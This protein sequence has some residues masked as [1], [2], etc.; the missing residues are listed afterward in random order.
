MN[1]N[2]NNVLILG[3]VLIIFCTSCA[4][5][6]QFLSAYDLDKAPVPLVLNKTKTDS[7]VI[8]FKGDNRQ[9]LLLKN[10]KDT[11]FK[12]YNI[13]SVMFKSATGNQLN[14]WMIKDSVN[15]NNGKT[16]LYFHGAGGC[17]LTQFSFMVPFEKKGYQVF[18]V[19]FSGYGFSGGEVS[20][21]TL[22]VDGESS[23]DYVKN[24]GDVK[25]TKLILYGQSYGA[26]TAICV[27]AKH[28]AQSKIDL[29]IAEAG[30]NSHKNLSD[31]TSR[32]PFIGFMSR[33][34]VKE[35]YS[36]RKEIHK[37]KIPKVI[38]HSETDETIPYKMG[39]DLYGK[40]IEPKTFIK[41]T[42]K[43]IE[44]PINNMDEIEAVINKYLEVK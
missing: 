18:V 7:I 34:F 15:T 20:R 32:N 37:I 43:H 17:N 4:Y 42:G 12:Q 33:I 10:N 23:I 25:G 35:M 21:Q 40:A 6:K 2:I 9:P 39:V 3:F 16:I 22:L 30:F 44:G 5:N 29:L 24:R 1:S 13:E 28:N 36:G 14:G 26:H 38:I 11:L 41:A 31:D 27:A 19:D 8:Y